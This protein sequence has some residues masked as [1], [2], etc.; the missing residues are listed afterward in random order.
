[1]IDH[2]TLDDI[3]RKISSAL[4]ESARSLQKDIEKNIRATMSTMFEKMDLV[5]REELE[6]QKAV[7]ARTRAKVDALEQKIAELER[8]TAPPRT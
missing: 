2:S 6:V 3:V 4:P 5:T 8:D 7:L 1:M